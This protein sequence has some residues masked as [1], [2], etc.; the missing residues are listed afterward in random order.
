M[1]TLLVDPRAEVH[2]TSGILPTKRIDLPNEHIAKALSNL[3]IMFM[4]Q[5]LINNVN[6]FEIPL[7]CSDAGTWSWIYKSDVNTWKEI[8]A[9]KAI[10]QNAQLSSDSKEIYE[11]WLKIKN[12]L[13]ND[14]KKSL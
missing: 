10:S 14:E 6:D 4:V 3:N 5:P 9:I 2:L 1:V 8:S 12:A 13:G 11:G 7:P